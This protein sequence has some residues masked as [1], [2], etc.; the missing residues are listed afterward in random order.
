MSL[1]TRTVIKE[2][3]P[4]T[5]SD[6]TAQVYRDESFESVYLQRNV[7]KAPKL[8]ARFDERAQEIYAGLDTRRGY[9]LLQEYYP[10]VPTE[11]LEVIAAVLNDHCAQSLELI[12]RSF[13]LRNIEWLG[14]ANRDGL[15]VIKDG[16][17]R[18]IHQI[19]GTDAVVV[20]PKR[21]NDE[22]ITLAMYVADC[23]AI[24]IIDKRT[25]AFAFV[26]AGRPCTGLRLVE[27][28]VLTMK[29]S[30]GSDPADLVAHL[31]EGVCQY[32]YLIDEETYQGFTD[33]F[34][35]EA[36]VTKILAKY[37][38]AVKRF[39]INEERNV[40]L[41]LYAFNSHLLARQGV[42]KI[43]IA[44]NCTARLS[45]KCP[46]LN[47]YVPPENEQLFYSHSRTKNRLVGWKMT[48]GETLELNT[49]HLGTPRNWTCI[50][51]F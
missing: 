43:T 25:K 12:C 7:Q 35:G 24:S 36:E 38:E 42:G 3:Q 4:V 1:A 29:E 50:T 49:Y 15:A 18:G 31:G 5:E 17:A 9:S 19:P 44:R 27:K 41:D 10:D 47:G 11:E 28:A 45:P 2:S 51:R 22:P 26:H 8:D 32:C 30:F 21:A 33:D 14:L 34:G 40:G 23:L 39:E 13:D 6:I 16:A 46:S 37:P 20:G 48:N